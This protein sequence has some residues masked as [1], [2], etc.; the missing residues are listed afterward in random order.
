MPKTEFKSC[1]F[2]GDSRIYLSAIPHHDDYPAFRIE[3]TKCYAMIIGCSEKDT[4]RKWNTRVYED[5]YCGAW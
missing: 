5:D 1:P 2:C 4:M 3:C